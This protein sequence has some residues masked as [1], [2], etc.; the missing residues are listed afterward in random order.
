MQKQRSAAM[1][2]D[3][4]NLGTKL[5][6][7]GNTAAALANFKQRNDVARRR[8]QVLSDQ[9][10]TVDFARY[11]DTLKNQDIVNEIEKQFTSFQPKKY[12]VQRQI[13]AIEAFEAQAVK[14]AEETKGKVDAELKDLEKTLKNIETARPFEDLTVVRIRARARVLLRRA[15]VSRDF[16]S[17]NEFAGRRRCRSPR[18]RQACRT[19]RL[20]EP[21]ASPWPG[22]LHR[23]SITICSFTDAFPRRNSAICLRYS[24]VSANVVL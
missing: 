23:C 14:S 21:L 3:W 16:T 11:R 6:L 10:Q 8:V 22:T 18:Y 4:S 9:A 15:S 12:D 19:T 2:I 5:G 24:R 17:A 13:K 7:R 1:K 20:Q